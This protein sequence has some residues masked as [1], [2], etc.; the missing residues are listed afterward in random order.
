M[1]ERDWREAPML[2]PKDQCKMEHEDYLAW[3][4]VNPEGRIQPFY[5]NDKE[6]QAIEAQW[7]LERLDIE[8]A[9]TGHI[10]QEEAW[11]RRQRIM[12]TIRELWN[13]RENLLEAF[14]I[15]P[16]L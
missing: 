4:K 7:E 10:T 5:N 2:S 14:G 11:E 15:W 3:R 13:D 9:A 6:G 16:C 8:L 1:S 12:A